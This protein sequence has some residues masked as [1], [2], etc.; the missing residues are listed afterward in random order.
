MSAADTALIILAAGLSI[1]FGHEDKLMADLLGQ[2]VAGHV[3]G[4]AAQMPFARRLAVVPA[5]TLER[6]SLFKQA[7][8]GL[9]TN[10]QPE[11]GQ[12]ESLRFGI[13]AALGLP[14]RHIMVL[15][16][17]MPFVEKSHLEAILRAGITNDVVMSQAREIFMPP[18]LF[19]YEAA[20]KLIKADQDLGGKSLFSKDEVFGVPMGEKMARDIDVVEDLLNLI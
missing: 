5:N 6:R 7:G 19:S 15:L 2:P 1:R 9:V 14:V 12:G 8:F 3:I 20:K 10:P 16:A 18:S 17:D 13:E 11:Q 4:A